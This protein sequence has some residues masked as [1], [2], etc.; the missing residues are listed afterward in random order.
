MIGYVA[1]SSWLAA[2]AVVEAG[3]SWSLVRTIPWMLL[4]SPIGW[5]IGL[6]GDTWPGSASRL[7]LVSALAVVVAMI[8]LGR[9]TPQV[10]LRRVLWCGGAALFNV[11]GM[12]GFGPA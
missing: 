3:A 12:I 6:C 4:G 11:V 1:P 7:W 9:K 8:W 5:V 10:W 2:Q